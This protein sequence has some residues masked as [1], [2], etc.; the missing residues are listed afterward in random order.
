MKTNKLISLMVAL[1]LT[2]NGCNNAKVVGSNQELEGK[3]PAPKLMGEISVEEA[4]NL[5]KSV[6][7]FLDKPLSI[8]QI[9][10]LLWSAQGIT[11]TRGELKLRTAPA[12]GAT[13][14]L[15]TYLF[16]ASGGYKYN[17]ADHSLKK[18]YPDDMRIELA[19]ASHGQTS[20]SCAHAVFVFTYIEERTSQRYGERAYRYICMEAGHVAQNI[21][22]QAVAL[23]LGSVPVGAF[24]DDKVAE[25]MQLPE[26]EIPLYIIPVGYSAE[27]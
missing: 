25:I 22:L 16:T 1:V 23:G 20:V 13:Y 12:A 14:P 4:L 27:E 10:Q 21:H 8:D 5:R 2:S 17:P 19:Q 11:R 15:E 7:K 9:S 18:V 26:N 3:L 24:T 6:R